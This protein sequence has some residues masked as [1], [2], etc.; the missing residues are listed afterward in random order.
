MVSDLSDSPKCYFGQR[1]QFYVLSKASSIKSLGVKKV[2]KDFKLP[3]VDTTG[4]ICL[5]NWS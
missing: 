5:K 2:K 1:V 3:E 4:S